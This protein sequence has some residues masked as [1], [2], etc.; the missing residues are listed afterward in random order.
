MNQLTGAKEALRQVQEVRMKSRNHFFASQRTAND[1]SAENFAL[2]AQLAE[3]NS[4][5][6]VMRKRYKEEY[7]RNDT[8]ARDL[9]D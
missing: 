5:L 9:Y 3:A 2:R 6:A 8:W 4:K 1:L 7:T